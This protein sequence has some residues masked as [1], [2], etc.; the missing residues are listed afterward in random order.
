MPS[1]WCYPPT[2]AWY[3]FGIPRFGQGLRIT[4]EVVREILSAV[5]SCLQLEGHFLPIHLLHEVEHADQRR[6]DEWLPV[7]IQERHREGHVPV[8]DALDALNGEQDGLQ[9]LHEGPAKGPCR[10]LIPPCSPRDRSPWTLDLDLE[11]LVAGAPPALRVGVIC[12]T[13]RS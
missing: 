5:R 11:E 1:G 6:V 4:G 13:S 8:D 7:L 9:G 2:A 12:S 3:P 10:F